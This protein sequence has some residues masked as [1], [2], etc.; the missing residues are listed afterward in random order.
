MNLSIMILDFQNFMYDLP[1][2][3]AKG[4]GPTIT[5]H[6]FESLLQALGLFPAGCQTCKKLSHFGC[7]RNYV[8]NL[9]VKF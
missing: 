5:K 9:L 2:I 4:P 1:K 7:H 8:F 6:D 3:K